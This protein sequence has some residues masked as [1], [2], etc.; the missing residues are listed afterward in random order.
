MNRNFRSFVRG[1][2]APHKPHVFP[3]IRHRSR[4]RAHARALA[5]DVVRALED[6]LIAEEIED[7]GGEEAFLEDPGTGEEWRAWFDCQ[8]VAAACERLGLVLSVG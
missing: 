8:D 7:A 5:A 6:D 4:E 1:R 3:W 2:L